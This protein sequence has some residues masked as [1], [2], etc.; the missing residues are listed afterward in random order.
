MGFFDEVEARIADGGEASDIEWTP[1]L[2]PMR[3][4]DHEWNTTLT[5]DEER[6]FR[7]WLDDV[8]QELDE[9]VNPDRGNYDYRGAWK[10]G[11][12]PRTDKDHHWASRWKHPDHPHRIVRVVNKYIDSTTGDPVEIAWI[13]GRNRFVTKDGQTFDMPPGK[14]IDGKIAD[15]DIRKAMNWEEIQ[16]MATETYEYETEVTPSTSIGLGPIGNFGGKATMWGQRLITPHAIGP[17][18][19]SEA[20]KNATNLRDA[21]AAYQAEEREAWKNVA[22]ALAEK[23]AREGVPRTRTK[24]HPDDERAFRKDFEEKAAL[25]GINPN[26]DDEN[27][28]YDWRGAWRAGA[29]PEPGAERREQDRIKE[30]LGKHSDKPFVQR[31]LDPKKHK[32]IKNADGSVSTHKMAYA[33]TDEG[34]IVFPTVVAGEDGKLVELPHDK[35]VEHAKKTGN[36]IQFPTVDEAEWFSMNYKK[37]W[38]PQKSAG[39]VDLHPAFLD[40]DH[41]ER[42][43]GKTDRKLNG[44]WAVRNAEREARGREMAR[45]EAEGA[46]FCELQWMFDNFIPPERLI[47]NPEFLKKHFGTDDLVE[48]AQNLNDA[49]IQQSLSMYH[50]A[51]GVGKD[52]HWLFAAPKLKKDYTPKEYQQMEPVGAWDLVKKSWENGDFA[53]NIPWSPTGLFKALFKKGVF[54]RFINNAYLDTEQGKS[55]QQRDA[56][57]IFNWLEEAEELSNR[58]W[59][60]SAKVGS[61]VMRSLPHMVEFGTSMGMFSGLKSA[62]KAGAYRYGRKALRDY[63]E[64]AG[65]KGLMKRIGG[66]FAKWGGRAGL[67]T[68]PQVHRY[69]AEALHMMSDHELT[70]DGR[71]LISE[72]H[73]RPMAAIATAAFRQYVENFGEEG[74]EMLFKPLWMLRQ[75]GKYATKFDTVPG[76]AKSHNILNRIANGWRAANKAKAARWAKGTLKAGGFDGIFFEIGEERLADSILIGF[77]MDPRASGDKRGKLERLVGAHTDLDQYF[78]E[79]GIFAL[80]GGT[81]GVAGAGQQMRRGRRMGKVEERRRSVPLAQRMEERG[82]VFGYLASDKDGDIVGPHGTSRRD[83]A[84][85][86]ARLLQDKLKQPERRIGVLAAVLRGREANKE[87]TPKRLRDVVDHIDG[88]AADL[89]KKAADN[90]GLDEVEQFELEALFS[91]ED[92]MIVAKLYGWEIDEAEAERNP[93]LASSWKKEARRTTDVK[94]PPKV[95]RVEVTFTDGADPKLSEYLKGYLGDDV[96]DNMSDE[97]KLRLGNDF[98]AMAEFMEPGE[99]ADTLTE[100]QRQD[101]VLEEYEA[102]QAE[103]AEKLAQE[104]KE[105][106][107]LFQARISSQLGPENVST[108]QEALDMAMEWMPYR[109]VAEEYAEAFA[110]GDSKKADGIWNKAVKDARVQLARRMKRGQQVKKST[111]RMA[112]IKRADLKRMG[113]ESQ[114]QFWGVKQ[115]QTAEEKQRAKDIAA[116]TARRKAAKQEGKQEAY[117]E[118]KA[119]EEKAAAEQA[120]REAEEARRATVQ[121]ELEDIA[122]K[123][124]TVA[125]AIAELPG[126]ERVEIEQMQ[127]ELDERLEAVEEGAEPSPER[128]KAEAE[129]LQGIVDKIASMEEIRAAA[130]KDKAEKIQAV[131]ETIEKEVQRPDFD[132]LSQGKI[133]RIAPGTSFQDAGELLKTLVERKVLAPPDEAGR[134]LP[135][136]TDTVTDAAPDGTV[137]Y[138]GNGPA[139]AVAELKPTELGDVRITTGPRLGRLGGMVIGE[140]PT[141][142]AAES[143]ARKILGPAAQE[144][145]LAERVADLTESEINP[146]LGELGQRKVEGDTNYNPF[147]RAMADSVNL[148]LPGAIDKEATDELVVSPRPDADG[149]TVSPADRA[150]EPEGT[151]VP[152]AVPDQAGTD[153]APG[154]G[155]GQPGSAGLP[156]DGR[157]GGRG[158]RGDGTGAAEGGKPAE[159]V[160]RGPEV[161]PEPAGDGGPGG[162]GAA[163]TGREAGPGEGRGDAEGDAAGPESPAEP[164]GEAGGT[165]ATGVDESTPGV[166]EGDVDPGDIFDDLKDVFSMAVPR[167]PGGRLAMASAVDPEILMKVAQAGKRLVNEKGVTDF[168]R[169]AKVFRDNLGEGTTPYLPSA[170]VSIYK[171]ADAAIREKMTDPRVVG[172]MTPQDVV[173]MLEQ[174]AAEADAKQAEA[175][176]AEAQ[177]KAEEEAAAKKKAEEDRLGDEG[178]SFTVEYEPRSAN[179]AGGVLV[180][181]NMRDAIHAAIDALEK[182]VGM[183]VDAYVADQ[184]G[185]GTDEAAIKRLHSAFYGHQVDALG[186][187]MYQTENDGALIIGDDT[188]TGKGRIGA[189]MLLWSIKNGKKPIFLTAKKDLL[190]DIYRDL[191]AVSK[192]LGKKLPVPFVLNEVDVMDPESGG[193]EVLFKKKSGK[194][195][196]DFGKQYTQGV[197]APFMEGK[198]LV[199]GTYSQIAQGGVNKKL[200]LA[201]ASQDNMMILDESH[202]AAGAD[203]NTGVMVRAM[204]EGAGENPRA[205]GVTYLSATYAKRPDTLGLY[206]RTQLGK[207]GMNHSDLVAA[208]EAGGVPMQEWIAEALALKGQMVRREKDFSG[209]EFGPLTPYESSGYMEAEEKRK[210]LEEAADK[211]GVS[212]KA[213]WAWDSRLQKLVSKIVLPRL[214]AEGKIKVDKKTGQPVYNWAEYKEL[215]HTTVNYFLL[216]AKADAAVAETLRYLN[217]PGESGD[218]S[219]VITTQN[220]ME[221]VIDDMTDSRIWDGE[222]LPTDFSGVLVWMM[223]KTLRQFSYT[224]AAGKKDNIY[225]ITDADLKAAGLLDEFKAEVA[226]VKASQLGIP[227]SSYDYIRD[228]LEANGIKVAEASGRKNK[229]KDGKLVPRSTEERNTRTVIDGFNRGD[230]RVVIGNSTISTGVSMHTAPEF[231]NDDQRVMLTIQPHEE[232][233]TQVQM[234]GR[235]NRSGQIKLPEIRLLQT[236]LPIELRPHGVL[237][238]K[239]ASLNANVSAE[240]E[241]SLKYGSV[242]LFDKFGD[243]IVWDLFNNDRELGE[244]MLVA[245]QDDGTMAKTSWNKQEGFAK[246][247]LLR[248]N[249]LPVKE[250]RKLWDRVLQSYLDQMDQLD[251]D[252]A[253]PNKTYHL[254]WDAVELPDK[255][256]I[257]ISFGSDQSNPLTS[258]A[259]AKWYR[260]KNLKRPP[261]WKDVQERVEKN[262]G[263]VSAALRIIQEQSMPWARELMKEGTGAR[264][265]RAMRQIREAVRFLNGDT[266]EELRIGAVYDVSEKGHETD[267]RERG[268]WHMGMVL[269]GVKVDQNATNPAARSNVY[270]FFADPKSSR[271]MKL[272]WSKVS[273]M[274]NRAREI[275]ERRAKDEGAANSNTARATDLDYA[276]VRRDIGKSWDARRGQEYSDIQL[277]TGNLLQAMS[278]VIALGGGGTV[279]NFTMADGSTMRG[280]KPKNEI[281]AA[282]HVTVDKDNLMKIINGANDSGVLNIAVSAGPWRLELMLGDGR[283]NV[284][285]LKGKV[286]N[287]LKDSEGLLDL[288]DEEAMTETKRSWVGT[289]PAFDMESLVELI[290]LTHPAFE[291]DSGA[292]PADLTESLTHASPDMSTKPLRMG[293]LNDGFDHADLIGGGRPEAPLTPEQAKAIMDAREV[294]SWSMQED[295]EYRVEMP[296]LVMLCKALLNKY[297]RLADSLGK[298]VLG[299]F[300]PKKGKTE[301]ALKFALINNPELAAKVLAH[302]LGHMNDYFDKENIVREDNILNILG[303]IADFAAFQKDLIAATPEA[304][305]KNPEVNK[306]AREKLR[307]EA[308]AEA[309]AEMEK[310]GLKPEGT[311]YREMWKELFRDKM[312]Q[313]SHDL[314]VYTKEEIRY[315]LERLTAWWNPWNIGEDKKYDTYR[316]SSVELYAEA[317]SVLLMAPESMRIKAPKSYRMIM[318]WMSRKPK[319]KALYDQIQKDIRS[320]EARGAR[321]DNN[322]GQMFADHEEVLRTRHA[323]RGAVF[324]GALS[325]IKRNFYRRA[326]PLHKRTAKWRKEQG[327]KGVSEDPMVELRKLAYTDAA[328]N[329]YLRDFK[330][331]IIDRLEEI[332]ADPVDFAKYLFLRRAR[333]ER[334]ELWNPGGF[335]GET[336]KDTDE[337]LEERVGSEIYALFGELRKKLFQLR[338][339]H[340]FPVLVQEGMYTKKLYD[341]I[342]TN[343]DYV[344][345]DVTKF[346]EDRLGSE[347]LGMI[348]KQVGT[349]EGI[350]NV[351][352]ATVMKD[353]SLLMN[354]YANRAKRKTIQ[355]MLNNTDMK[356]IQPAKTHRVSI[357]RRKVWDE[358][359]NDWVEK[360]VFVR[361]PKEPRN[362]NWG[363]VTILQNG[364]IKGYY[365]PKELADLF[366]KD[367]FLGDVVFKTLSALAQPFK[368]MYVGMNPFFS[369]WNAQRDFRATVKQLPQLGAVKGPWTL[370]KYYGKAWT[371]TWADVVRG[372]QSETVRWMYENRAL[373]AGRGHGMAR[374]YLALK[375]GKLPSWYSSDEAGSVERLFDEY[376]IRE[377]KGKKRSPLNPLRWLGGLKNFLQNYNRF[378]ELL[379]KVAGA[380]FLRERTDLPEDKIV[381]LL[382]TRVGSPDFRDGGALR[383]IYNNIW[384]FSNAQTVGIQSAVE[385]VK[386]TPITYAVKTV[387][388]DIIPMALKY[389]ALYGLLP[390][391]DEWKETMQEIMKRVRKHDMHRKH[392]IPLW[393]TE[394]GEAAYAIL[395]MDFQGEMAVGALSALFESIND[396]DITNFN[397]FLQGEMPFSRLNPVIKIAQVAW[398]YNQGSNPIDSWTGRPIIDPNRMEAGGKYAAEDIFRWF[399]NQT[400]GGMTARAN[401]SGLRTVRGDFE[402][403]IK[404]T[405]FVE[406]AVSRLIRFSNRKEFPMDDPEVRKAGRMDARNSEGARKTI[407]KHIEAFGREKPSSKALAKARLAAYKEAKAKGYIPKSYKFGYW[408]RRWDNALVT[409]W[410]S[411]VDRVKRY[412]S[413][414][415]RRVLD[416]IDGGDLLGD[417]NKITPINRTAPMFDSDALDDAILEHLEGK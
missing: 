316:L 312:K 321:L 205:E 102:E 267:I 109:E 125:D 252:L 290:A 94:K 176:E 277:V 30:V 89:I 54:D 370:L 263:Q 197:K 10:G 158:P 388:Y 242:D 396:K 34:A 75:S 1:D 63:L 278:S 20:F 333:T 184:L 33:E 74:S 342:L 114:G 412:A 174:G 206:I 248:A 266:Q 305:E 167:G 202:M 195:K 76:L 318:S 273:W 110:A 183:T 66:E 134:Y 185:L 297:P 157:S 39:D 231:Q 204:L 251:E 19:S 357:G 347:G 139:T 359:A 401:R 175:K 161:I 306:E 101:S 211:L 353:L 220:T 5:L 245:Y 192:A 279:V 384:I 147:E 163:G 375:R 244:Q 189:G 299:H 188:G 352:D 126:P 295:L 329:M 12:D 59:T 104:K 11:V 181:R 367:V 143:I 84:V 106:D 230:F 405:W 43:R 191:Q 228:Q 128:R 91:I 385:T 53:N 98:E 203:S 345:F 330:R 389:A 380:K 288:L 362:K 343:E 196:A 9:P 116:A 304:Y 371:D 81:P 93:E 264:G 307:E 209:I 331:D 119:A 269:T 381:D 284:E 141:M 208:L 153:I 301:I 118:R 355:W 46:V 302:E 222:T 280:V 234:F 218:R 82:K 57:L 351:L 36:A 334:E 383:L 217:Q 348:H 221:T 261:S 403:R 376:Q 2:S 336:A 296:E 232:V 70:D 236:H 313:A 133:Q 354:G 274:Y 379:P 294:G 48:I 314:G 120:E 73:D 368:E 325:W 166:A 387:L 155:P 103:L 358:K 326:E 111:A 250:Q 201:V 121:G 275:A 239:M 293:K 319:V 410:G 308:K 223:N 44:Q 92:P 324:T 49:K 6:D 382:L 112:G 233:N 35:A 18:G 268:K 253:N 393:L 138:G 154:E 64:T 417:P 187:S 145:G 332:G 397:K 47:K 415:Q 132:Y 41:H 364:Q 282:P 281:E 152:P 338:E 159:P 265:S 337:A 349:L 315:E 142:T 77:N 180:P 246:R 300:V 216:S 13:D 136:V 360:E 406:P 374:P 50:A 173:D 60:R 115:P 399:W 400:L 378:W 249:L 160:G 99:D 186:M 256:K 292:V 178:I 72:F 224:D 365:V 86:I 190:T 58:E 394:E 291:V 199:M 179:K 144:K 323:M 210:M 4:P 62:L 255:G 135:A 42:F 27:Y 363:L 386:E 340:I 247:A 80:I 37:A 327:V 23:Q 162:E 22:M 408:K 14:I 172:Q 165:P 156:G 169:F 402:E 391:P 105:A 164:G 283:V 127:A 88:R 137:L 241:T 29:L 193:T 52:G 395:P 28:K 285:L 356:E 31:I 411:Q 328:A 303:R 151:A 238:K 67:R 168:Y 377:L 372:E 390:W 148:D 177:K 259:T 61:G 320:G 124:K 117:E 346:L 79:L 317:W 130:A 309:K 229:I 150:G 413:K 260:V 200:F 322:I 398:Q 276:R 26:P 257:P 344:T 240:A 68:L 87:T 226:K 416:G 392:I 83:R 170:Y 404:G 287:A 71:L 32:P 258:S 272:P 122:A 182:D 146:I 225:W 85:D 289:M 108:A 45:A 96:V 254:E 69:G 171:R 271:T 25:L 65:A 123:R 286:G 55:M 341:K 90:N 213:I 40:D 3:G 298:G 237:M 235:V 107:R 409:R 149:G 311:Q 339:H 140:V 262:K 214:V 407:R 212:M 24:L 21:V 97:E 198:D 219:L 414:S 243:R 8:N 7:S 131:A 335:I 207:V 38:E 51:G 310:L 78:T 56:A 194:E 369:I 113:Y 215:Y 15:L 373:I 95:D 361:Q 17:T 227:F 350:G 366:T 270:L 100:E 129:G 16:K